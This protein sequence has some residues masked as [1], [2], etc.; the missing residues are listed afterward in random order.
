MPLRGGKMNVI[1]ID[2]AV[3]WDKIVRSFKK[4]DVYWLSGYVKGFKIHGDG[5]PLL[6]HYEGYGTR[7]INVVMRRDVSEDRHFNGK[8]EKNKYIDVTTP[9]G[10]GGWIIEG[11]NSKSLFDD[12]FQWIK[13]EGI[14]CEFLRLHPM[15]RNHE[16][17]RDYYDIIQLG[18]VVHMDLTSPEDI[19]NNITS[20]NRNMIRKAL[21]NG[22]KIY[23]GRFPEVYDRFRNIYN[24]TMSKD[25]ADNYYFF[26]KEFYLSELDDLP[27]NSQIFWADMD[28]KTI[29]ASIILS[30]N[31]YM[32][33]HLS[34]SVRDYNTYAPTNLLLYEA[35]LWGHANG[36]RTFYLGG[37]V[38]SGDDNLF[39][40]KRAFYRGELNHFYIGKRIYD[41]EKYDDLA[42]FRQREDNSI[43]GS[44][45]F[46]IYRAEGN[47]E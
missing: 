7:G 41:K 39:R 35:A 22:I 20:K 4:Y 42:S 12:Y 30:A 14:I 1:T 34:G 27:Y 15:I 2:Q 5:E 11:N 32:N 40:F 33:Y 8:I 36:C 37:G 21:K 3:L 45:Y 44:Q 38:G 19:W 28:G 23:N 13:K 47:I 16:P 43:Q 31:G 26:E 46:P 10:Y 25:S 6:L 18:E 17:L 9:Y 24:E 29:A